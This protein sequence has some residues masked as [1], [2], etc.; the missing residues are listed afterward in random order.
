MSFYRAIV[1]LWI[2]DVGH[3][4][5]FFTGEISKLMDDVSA[6]LFLIQNLIIYVNFALK[7]GG[8]R[9]SFTREKLL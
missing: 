1:L 5:R 8:V 4:S 6:K 9:Y 3:S 7:I 2:E